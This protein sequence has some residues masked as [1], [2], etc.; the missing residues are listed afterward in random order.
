[1]KSGNIGSKVYKLI[2]EGNHNA[3][4]KNIL[5]IK[6]EKVN[7]SGKKV[8]SLEMS[9]EFI[10]IWIGNYKQNSKIKPLNMEVT[11]YVYS[12]FDKSLWVGGMFDQD[13]IIESRILF[14]K[15]V[16]YSCALSSM[17]CFIGDLFLIR[18]H[19]LRILEIMDLLK[20]NTSKSSVES[21]LKV[22]Y[23]MISND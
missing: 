8:I 10:S 19:D 11:L 12:R 9:N 18:P 21:Y 1:M 6:G 23:K 5:V 13:N 20:G 22:L 2:R 16:E 15:S 14:P 4:D 7:S 17:K 3:N